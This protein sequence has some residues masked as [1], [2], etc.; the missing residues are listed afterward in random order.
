MDRHIAGILGH[1]LISLLWGTLT[2]GLIFGW[3]A[4]P[5]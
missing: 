5:S 4:L 2:E 3:N 1:S